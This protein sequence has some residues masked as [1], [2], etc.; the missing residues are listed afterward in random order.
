ML[1]KTREQLAIFIMMTDVKEY[2]KVDNLSQY[3][4]IKYGDTEYCTPTQYGSGPKAKFPAQQSY[5]LSP[6]K[7]GD[8]PQVMIEVWTKES[9]LDGHIQDIMLGM[10]SITTDNL[11]IG[12]G[13]HEYVHLINGI[14]S[15][16]KI[17]IKSSFKPSQTF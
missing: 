1:S 4:K 11:K 10:C 14:K 2:P 6:D 15:I 16:G 9:E 12:E 8:H 17:E 3:V 13:L 5:D 7:Q